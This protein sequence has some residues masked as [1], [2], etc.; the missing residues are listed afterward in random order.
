MG[1]CGGVKS[2]SFS[3]PSRYAAQTICLEGSEKMATIW[4]SPRDIVSGRLACL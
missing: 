2:A 4:R 1:C 3:D